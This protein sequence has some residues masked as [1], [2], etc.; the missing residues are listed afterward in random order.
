MSA[1]G[2]PSSVWTSIGIESTIG[3]R[4]PR[5]RRHARTVSAAAVRPRP[6]RSAPAPVARASA[7]W[8]MRWL[9]VAAVVA[10]SPARTSSGVRALAASARPVMAFVNPGPWCRL[11]TPT[12]PVTRA[13]AS[14]MTTA[15]VS[16]R[17]Q[18]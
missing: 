3:R 13:H 17:A 7:S 18:W 14:V 12:R 1:A 6:I 9:T 10:T 2:S 15:P 4:S 5:A 8:S 16:C 11:H